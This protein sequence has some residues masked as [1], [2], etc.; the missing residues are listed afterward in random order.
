MGQGKTF[1]HSLTR[2]ILL[3]ATMAD[4]VMSPGENIDC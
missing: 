2:E 1:N 3:F 4:I